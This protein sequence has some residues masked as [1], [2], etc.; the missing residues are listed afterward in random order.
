MR[1]RS[2]SRCVTYKEGPQVRA[3]GGAKENA[4]QNLDKGP[5]VRLSKEDKDEMLPGGVGR[6]WPAS[7]PGAL[8][9]GMPPTPPDHLP[10][11]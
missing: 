1:K 7:H 4:P 11:V 8:R 3:N 9:R 6:T 10:Y 2:T 5:H